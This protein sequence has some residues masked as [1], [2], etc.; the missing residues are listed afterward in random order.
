MK[1]RIVGS[2]EKVNLPEL[3]VTDQIAK[4]DTGAYTGALHCTNIRVVNVAGKKV[5]RFTL[6]GDKKMSEQTTDFSVTNVRSA[7]G[8]RQRR[9]DINTTIEIGG[10]TF[11]L[12]IGLSDRSEMK[13]PILIGR[14]FLREHGFLVDVSQGT[15][16]DNERKLNR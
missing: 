13:R 6:L 14:R 1:D 10:E 9:Y 3:G 16:Y 12:R 11:P 15:E 5:L 4:I 7:F 2:F 8:Q